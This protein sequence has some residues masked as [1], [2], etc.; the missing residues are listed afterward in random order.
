MIVSG[1]LCGWLIARFFIWLLFRPQYPK[2]IAGITYI[3]ILPALKPILV[4]NAG[5]FAGNFDWKTRFLGNSTLTQLMP[6]IE[7]YVDEF[8][9]VRLKEAFPL[10]SNFMGEKTLLKFKETFIE[11]VSTKM[12]V[13]LEN[14]STKLA[15]NFDLKQMVQ[16]RIEKIDIS[17]LEST[18]KKI[19][20]KQLLLL[21]AAGILIGIFIAII[22]IIFIRVI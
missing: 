8:L 4:E 9:R 14:Y 16:E 19:A 17:M 20:K 11:E 3:G 12:P 21:Q 18:I 2:K 7:I 13:L 5:K 15:A 6:E 22:Q 1:A 10:L